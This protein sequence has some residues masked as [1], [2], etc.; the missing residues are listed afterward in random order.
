MGD[1]VTEALAILSKHKGYTHG[2]YADSLGKELAENVINRTAVV[3][4]VFTQIRNQG[5]SNQDLIDVSRV[6]IDSLDPS[7]MNQI[8]KDTSGAILLVRVKGYLSCYSEK[9]TSAARCVKID[10]AFARTVKPPT[11]EE[12]PYYTIDAGIVVEADAIAVLDKIGPLYFAKVNKKFNVNSGTRDAYRQAEAMYVVYMSGDRT[13]SLYN[14]KRANELIAIIKNGESKT[15]TVKKMGDLIQQYA[16]K[17]ILMSDHQKAGAIDISI[18][19]DSA[20]EV[21]PMTSSQQKIMMGIATKVTGFAALLE[22]R[23][24]HIHLKF[25]YKNL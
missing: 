9:F 8:L 11:K 15:V 5:Y 20:T 17:N 10:T 19:G 22:T 3:N 4:E 6:F 23:P 7:Q 16:D 12:S 21:P 24:P 14:R 13:L 18:M 1:V 2:L 25:K